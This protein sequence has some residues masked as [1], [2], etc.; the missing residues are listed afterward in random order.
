MSYLHHLRQEAAKAYWDSI[1]RLAEPVDG[2]TILDCGC[3]DGSGTMEFAEKVGAGR[4]EAIELDSENIRIATGQG[5][6]VH[7]SDLNAPFPIETDH[8]DGILANQ[9][10]EHLYNTDRFMAELLRVLKPGGWAILCTENLASWHNIGALVLGYTP[11]SLTNIS[12]LAGSLG[13]PLAFHHDDDRWLA[14]A[15]STYQHM[16]VFTL[17]GLAHLGKA[18]GFTVEVTEG[19]GYYPWPAFAWPLLTRLD[20]RHA[21]FQTLRLRK[22]A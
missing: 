9:V 5:I 16:R 3:G 7:A 13:N 12:S 8:F 20:K 6:H 21:A 22:P 17:T 10:I 15:R 19:I 4:V 2:G 14:T 1:Y 11:F 18:H